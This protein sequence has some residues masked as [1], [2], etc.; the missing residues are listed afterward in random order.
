MGRQQPTKR[1]NQT[2]S[3]L[4]LLGVSPAAWG[5]AGGEIP[6]SLP[7]EIRLVAERVLFLRERID[8]FAPQS[9]YMFGEIV[10]CH[11]FTS[12]LLGVEFLAAAKI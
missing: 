5:V 8:Y 2:D 9:V 6:D 10:N 12:Y 3:H 1:E 11:G 4:E 7:E